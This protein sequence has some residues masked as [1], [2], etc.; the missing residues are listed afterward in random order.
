M[1]SANPL[2][3]CRR[4]AFTHS[5]HGTQRLNLL[6]EP[7][8][9]L[10]VLLLQ[11]RDGLLQGLVVQSLTWCFVRRHRRQQRSKGRRECNH[12]RL[13]QGHLAADHAVPLKPHPAACSGP[14]EVASPPAAGEAQITQIWVADLGRSLRTFANFCEL[15]QFTNLAGRA[16]VL[17]AGSLAVAQLYSHPLVLVAGVRAG[18]NANLPLEPALLLMMIIVVY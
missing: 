12:L 1:L 16:P 2:R 5:G 14:L 8:D 18:G 6:G 9:L 7:R 15:L 11:T 4:D 10:L 3:R 13:V 17:A